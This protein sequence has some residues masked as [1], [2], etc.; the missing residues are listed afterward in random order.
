MSKKI[1]KVVLPVGALT[2]VGA[3][4][5]LTASQLAYLTDAESTTNTFTIG[6]VKVDVLEPH[7]PGNDSD[8]V[9]HIVP[10]EEIAKDPQIQNTGD[11]EAIAFAE[12]TIPIADVVVAKADGTKLDKALTELF[13]IEHYTEDEDGDDINDKTPAE[14]INDDWVPL[15][16][17]YTLSDGTTKEYYYNSDDGKYYEDASAKTGELTEIP[18]D[19]VSV[20]YLVGYNDTI[21]GAKNADE[22]ADGKDKV[23]TPVFDLVK[24]VNIIEGQIDKTAQDIVVTGKAIQ[25]EWLDDTDLKDADGNI[26]K[27]NDEITGATLEKV[28]NIYFNQSGDKDAADA[29]T[30][31]LDLKGDEN[32]VTKTT[33]TLKLTSNDIETSVFNVGDTKA[34]AAATIV[35]RVNDTTIAAETDGQPTEG[36]PTFTYNSSNPNVASIDKDGKL[37]LN[38]SGTATISAVTSDGATAEVKITVKGTGTED[39]V[40]SNS[41][42]DDS[43]QVS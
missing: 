2:L 15:R 26:V 33:V 7:Y 42:V 32:T 39:E 34:K 11:N 1:K 5:A 4:G 25:S 17:Q 18:A 24:L 19:S 20:T 21:K 10:N 40:S 41:Q 16:K 43:E 14:G 22:D 23:T 28:Y 38:T 9:T 37:T 8:D 3:I 36:Y 29:D 30:T 31:N 6:D 12:Y 13:T 27:T 35:Y